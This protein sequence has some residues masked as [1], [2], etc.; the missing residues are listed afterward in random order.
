MLP[1]KA[2]S[3]FTYVELTEKPRDGRMYITDVQLAKVQKSS[4]DRTEELTA[5]QGSVLFFVTSPLSLFHYKK[6]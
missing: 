5:D 1:P 3:S 4:I 6:E 2:P